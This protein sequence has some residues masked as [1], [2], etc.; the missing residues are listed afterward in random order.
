[1]FKNHSI[2]QLTYIIIACISVSYIVFISIYNFFSQ[3]FPS[4]L[5]K[6][7]FVLLSLI[8]NIFF[9]KSVL[10]TFIIRKI[11]V[12]YKIIREAK[13]TKQEKENIDI[14]GSTFESV[15]AD[16][17]EWASGTQ[18]EIESLKS[19]EE[20]RKSYVGN[21]SHELKTPIFSILGYLHT[22]VEGGINDPNIN[23]SYIQKAINNVDR[24]QNIVEDLETISL[25][26]S[27][28]VAL[29]FIKF[30]IKV[31]TKE[32]FEDLE[33][34]AFEKNITLKFKESASYTTYVNADREKIRQV[35]TNLIVNAIKYGN[36][37]GNVKISFYDIDKQ[38]LIEISDNG[39]GI[40]EKHLKHLF[41][42]FYRVDSSRSRRIGGSGLG[43]AIVKHIVE[44]HNQTINV[45]SSIGLGS[46]FGFTLEKV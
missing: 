21:I 41:D 20:Y 5:M 13:L 9:I 27:N 40:E 7:G 36:E 6:M 10:E 37:G 12:I 24:L 43:L 22:L 42:R 39:V 28:A 2:R 35:L 18:K 15:S 33:K 26:E 14:T 4:P 31:L 8:I 32:V 3:Y 34:M 23:K 19:L 29:N 11:K 17:L 44:A 46:T 45:R 16:V 25:L 30:D 1:M 38:V